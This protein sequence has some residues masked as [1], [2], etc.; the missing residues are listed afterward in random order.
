MNM[1]FFRSI[2]SML[3]AISLFSVMAVLTIIIGMFWLMPG[4]E[5]MYNII[6]N[7][8]LLPI[9]SLISSSV[10]GKSQFILK[11]TIPV[12][13]GIIGSVVPKVVFGST[14]MLF[15]MLVFVPGFL[16]MFISNAIRLLR[17]PKVGEESSVNIV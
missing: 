8:I 16:G 12:L 3:V 7:Y 10:I 2:R 4:D 15:F 5:I 9:V 13:F 11:W 17:K 14:E 6:C 1:D